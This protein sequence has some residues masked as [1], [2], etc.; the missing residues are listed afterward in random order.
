MK[1]RSRIEKKKSENEFDFED[2]LEQM[3]QIKKMGPINQLLNDSR[4]NM[5]N[6]GCRSNEKELPIEAIIQS[7]L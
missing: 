6:L 1:R 3:Q 4:M 7:I 2:F 5:Q